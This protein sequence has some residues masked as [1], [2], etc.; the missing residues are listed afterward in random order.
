MCLFSTSVLSPLYLCL[1][2]SLSLSVSICLCSHVRVN[3]KPQNPHISAIYHLRVRAHTSNRGQ[4]RKTQLGDDLVLTLLLKTSHNLL[5]G[6][7][8]PTITT[9]LQP[10]DDSCETETTMR[11]FCST[12]RNASI[13]K[14]L[15]TLTWCSAGIMRVWRRGRPRVR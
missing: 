11:S 9:Y 14:R 12:S 13:L 10:Q 8:D 6:L 1:S 2:L 3:Q 15:R 4:T 5:R 7:L